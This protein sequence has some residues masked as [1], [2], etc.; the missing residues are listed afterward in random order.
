MTSEPLHENPEVPCGRDAGRVPDYGVGG[1]QTYWTGVLERVKRQS[2][3]HDSKED[4]A[5]WR[6]DPLTR[7]DSASERDDE[8]KK[9]IVLRPHP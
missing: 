4:G 1:L 9:R 3:A 6:E 7:D 5:A 2:E 8:K